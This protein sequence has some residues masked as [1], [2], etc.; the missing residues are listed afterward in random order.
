MT[1]NRIKQFLLPD[2]DR[3]FL[4]RILIVA[5]TAV[6]VFKYVFIPFRIHG[7]SMWPTYKDGAV[8][9]SFRPAYLFSK[10]G[11]NDVVTIRLAGNRVMLLKRIV[12]LE[13]DTVAFTDGR[14]I[15]NQQVVNEP[16]VSGPCD[17][18][19]ASRLVKPGHVYV[20]G[21]NRSVPMQTHHF[22]QTPVQRITGAVLW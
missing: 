14:L 11:R 10:P 2:V 15:V 12:A 5:V 16:Y 21:D 22:G 1:D 17:W 19:L 4:V 3:K 8:N 20:V 13:N 18:N 7:D 6:V 9:F